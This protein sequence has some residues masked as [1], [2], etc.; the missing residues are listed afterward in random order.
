MR[1]T[2]QKW[3]NSLAVR[4]PKPFVEE[5]HIAS[6]S[7]VDLTVDDGRII[8][9]PQSEAKYSLTELL[10]GVTARNRHSE[11]DTGT[12]VGQEVW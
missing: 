9:V 8:I 2:V 12:A 5:I 11:T 6:G 7:E 4:I 1:T 10:Q 3:G